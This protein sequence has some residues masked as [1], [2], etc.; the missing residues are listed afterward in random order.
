MTFFFCFQRYP[1][2]SKFENMPVVKEKKQRIEKRSSSSPAK[3]GRPKGSRN[4]SF[5]LEEEEEHNDDDEEEEENNNNKPQEEKE[6]VQ[7]LAS[8]LKRNRYIK[9]N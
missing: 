9:Q 4:R 1:K 2:L 3:R 5:D 7:S 8:K 6:G